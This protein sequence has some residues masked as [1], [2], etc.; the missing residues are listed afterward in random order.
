MNVR[1]HVR[2]RPMSQR[3]AADQCV[4]CVTV[5]PER[6]SVVVGR[7]K[8]F[9]FDGVHGER[10][11]QAE[12]YAACGARL[13]EGVMA[14]YNARVLAYGQ[15]GSGKTYTMGTDS[16]ALAARCEDGGAVLDGGAGIIPRVVE[17]IFG[18]IAAAA[19]DVVAVVRVS[20]LEIYRCGLGCVCVCVCV[21]SRCALAV[22]LYI[23]V[24]AWPRG[25][26]DVYRYSGFGSGL[27]A[28]T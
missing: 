27:R 22:W 14:G 16:G 6:R 11:P 8:E 26:V 25:V 21:S 24:I 10:A 23:G 20:F 7:T 13:V 1:V 3:E 28:R 15:T 5:L 2:V 18:A 19:D 4:G 17:G 12:L 9:T